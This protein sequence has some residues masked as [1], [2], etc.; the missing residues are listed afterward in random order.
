LNV[1]RHEA[2]FAHFGYPGDDLILGVWQSD[3]RSTN[4]PPKRDDVFAIVSHLL[5][6]AAKV[7]GRLHRVLLRGHFQHVGDGFCLNRKTAS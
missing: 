5:V 7:R 6:L 4:V 3:Q 2:R 1:I